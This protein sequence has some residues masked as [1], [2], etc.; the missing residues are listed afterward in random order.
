MIIGGT[1]IKVHALSTLPACEYYRILCQAI[2]VG[3][4]MIIYWMTASQNRRYTILQCNY[5]VNTPPTSWFRILNSAARFRCSKI[6]DR[7]FLPTRQANE[8]AVQ[9]DKR[10]KTLFNSDLRLQLTIYWKKFP[11]RQLSWIGDDLEN[12]DCVAEEF[13]SWRYVGEIH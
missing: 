9:G 7:H 5:I 12:D 4:T 10:R 6:L 1:E 8:F 13:P 2:S 11:H 3:R